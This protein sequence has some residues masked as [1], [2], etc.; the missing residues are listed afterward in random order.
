MTDLVLCIVSTTMLFVIFKYFNRYRVEN[1]QAIT[2]NYVVAG[3]LGLLLSEQ[4]INPLEVIH[5]PWLPGALGMGMCFIVTFS[6][7][8]L[9]SQRVGVGITSV[10]NKMSM[11]IPVI[12][13]VVIFGEGLG[14]LKL[15]GAVLALLA[16]V[17]TI[18]PQ[19]EPQFDIKD[20]YLPILIFFGSGMLDT[21]LNWM[22]AVKMDGD[23]FAHFSSAL[24]FMAAV[25]GVGA[26][27]LRRLR[28]SVEFN[29]T[30]VIAGIALGIPNYFSI[31]F[32][33]RA[34]DRP[35]LESTVVF[36][37]VN[38]GIV[39]LSTLLAFFL[40]AERPSRINMGG[41]A[42]AVI[43]IILMSF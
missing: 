5:E 2:V 11:V 6:L 21:V 1:L 17:L 26:L 39:L 9:S 25:T 33:L 14:G 3:S 27:L 30:S 41:V 18:W 29:R 32:L 10:A 19:K 7:I 8:A 43:S 12:A 28:H 42:L 31:Y 35:G 15:V 37:V 36:P 20:I 38:T 34:L 4:A 13:G 24:F 16:V 22:R 23:D 40:F